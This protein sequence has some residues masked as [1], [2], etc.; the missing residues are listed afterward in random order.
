MPRVMR[1]IYLLL[2]PGMLPYVQHSDFVLMSR[3]S[4]RGG[5][6]YVFAPLWK[7]LYD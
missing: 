1:G 3:R 5:F 6:L 4:L 2:I 7:V